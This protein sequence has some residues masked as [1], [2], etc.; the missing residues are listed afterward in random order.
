[1]KGRKHFLFLKGHLHRCHQRQAPGWLLLPWVVLAADICAFILLF[2]ND[3]VNKLSRYAKKVILS[4]VPE[5]EREREKDKKN[6]VTIGVFLS[7]SCKCTTQKF[8]F[9]NLKMQNGK[10]L[11]KKCLKQYP[12][13]GLLF[14]FVL[15][16]CLV[17]CVEFL[18]VG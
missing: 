17:F 16:V 2:F 6:H 12:T 1:M 18:R 5:R 9:L 14:F 8:C 11:S 10:S 7:A 4:Q 15:L 3:Q 13:C